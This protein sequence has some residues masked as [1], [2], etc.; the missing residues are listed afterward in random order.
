MKKILA[1][2]LVLMMA[3]SLAATAETDSSTWLC[4]EKTT[5]TVCTWDAASQAFPTVSN[6]LRFWQWL[7]DYTNVHIEWEV[8]SRADYT[9]V[10]TAKLAA[11]EMTTDIMMVPNKTHINEAGA[12]GL[13]IDMA[14]Y[15]ETCMPHTQ[16]WAVEEN[17]EVLQSCYAADGSLYYIGGQVSPDINHKVYMYNAAWLEKLGA[18][19]PTTLDEFT[20]LVYAM[21]AA[22]DLNGNGEDDE[23]ILTT[24]GTTGFDLLS[25][26]FGTELYSAGS[27]GFRAVDGKVEFEYATEDYKEY[28]TYLNQLYA[29]GIIDPDFICTADEMSQKIAQDQ[30]GIFMYYSG[31]SISY[32]K[33]TA[34]GQADPRGC[35]YMVGGPL[36][37]PEG[38]QY[39]IH[40]SMG[41]DLPTGVTKNCK[42]PE[43]AIR[44]LDT[45]LSDPITVRTRTCG[46][47]GESFNFDENGEVELILREDGTWG[48][49]KEWGCGQIALPHH[50]VFSSLMNGKPQWYI[51]Q[52][53]VFYKDEYL[54]KPGSVPVCTA[55]TAA[56]QE[57][58]DVVKTDI[59]TYR[60][61]MTAK[62]ITG[63][64]SLE[65]WDEYVETLYGLGLQDWVD[66]MQMYYD[67]A[68]A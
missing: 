14:P 21:K 51:D 1:L 15:V 38:H 45:L 43:L 18:E 31:F 35:H 24:N 59:E 26:S 52:Y 58:I 11:G 44:W 5:L 30:V 64:E 66:A 8:H 40:R 29:D 16:R 42:N 3:L 36:E 61:E 63:E 33:L 13:L 4:E 17:P 41:M 2:V 20:D 6:D 57:L 12:S 62:F 53:N 68:L 46:F 7:E 10:Y 19:V 65:G 50:Q 28:M 48:M 22:G 54:F 55:H 67:R 47:E 56:E 27:S 32:G 34:A 60:D 9:T 37:G 23:L 49:P 39:Y 25:N